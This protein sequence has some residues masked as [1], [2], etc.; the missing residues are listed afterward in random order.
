MTRRTILSLPALTLAPALEVT[1]PA[2]PEQRLR[3]T[4]ARCHRAEAAE[5]EALRMLHAAREAVYGAMLEGASATAL[6]RM[7]E[8]RRQAREEWESTQRETIEAE[9]AMVAAARIVR[10]GER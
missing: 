5:A 4:I 9:R 8:A 3:E 6:A 1:A 7:V 10:E 2:T